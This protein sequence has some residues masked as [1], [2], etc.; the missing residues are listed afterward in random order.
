MFRH[1]VLYAY[2]AEYSEKEIQEVYEELERISGRL[3][4]RLSYSWGV[5]DSHEGRNCGYYSRPYYRL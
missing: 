1:I 5:Y 2:R 4:G 3:E